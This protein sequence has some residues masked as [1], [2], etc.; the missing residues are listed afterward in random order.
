MIMTPDR[1]SQKSSKP[2]DKYIVVG[3]FDVSDESDYYRDE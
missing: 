2:Y 3:E 1:E